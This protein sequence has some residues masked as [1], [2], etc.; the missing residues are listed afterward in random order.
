MSFSFSAS[1][2]AGGP[3]QCQPPTS[4]FREEEQ[5]TRGTEYKSQE[6]TWE[7]TGEEDAEDAGG[8]CLGEPLVSSSGAEN[9]EDDAALANLQKCVSRT[10]AKVFFAHNNNNRKVIRVRE[11]YD[12]VCARFSKEY[13]CS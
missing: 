3:P 4:S 7:D 12:R 9:E 5:P 13:I 8:R 1:G 6:D 10:F 11:V 2:D